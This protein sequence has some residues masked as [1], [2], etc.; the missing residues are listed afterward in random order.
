MIPASRLLAEPIKGKTILMV[1][2]NDERQYWESR[3][4]G[5]IPVRTSHSLGF[6]AVRKAFQVASIGANE[7]KIAY[8]LD[9]LVPE[10]PKTGEQRALILEF[11]NRLLRQ[12]NGPAEEPQNDSP[13][14]GYRSVIIT[15]ATLC[16]KEACRP[17][18]GQAIG[19]VLDKFTPWYRLFR[20]SL[21]SLDREKVI[22]LVQQVLHRSLPTGRILAEYDFADQIWLPAILEDMQLEP[23]DTLL[24]ETKPGFYR[25]ERILLER[26]Q[27]SGT[28][29]VEVVPESDSPPDVSRG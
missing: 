9:E 13:Q 25:A 18:D 6:R 10:E 4:H 14:H 23:L 26:W 27:R 7:L 1:H 17:D 8:M 12:P 15:L 2:L 21:P 19:Y 3:L 5:R 29:I 24:I 28:R 16:K 20:S 11:I 22:A